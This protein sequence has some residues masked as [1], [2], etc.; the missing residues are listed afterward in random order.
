[1]KDFEEGLEELREA[2]DR[3]KK[4]ETLENFEKARE[5]KFQLQKA[6]FSQLSNPIE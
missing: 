1:M 3:F 6:V 2:V 4:N 5:L